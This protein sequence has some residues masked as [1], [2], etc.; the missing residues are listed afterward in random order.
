MDEHVVAAVIWLDEPET[1]V[2]VEEFHCTRCHA[3]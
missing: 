2:R 3:L 1:L